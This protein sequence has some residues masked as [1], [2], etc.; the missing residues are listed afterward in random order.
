VSWNYLAWQKAAAGIWAAPA[1][2]FSP[3][4]AKILWWAP[5]LVDGPMTL[6]IDSIPVGRYHE[7]YRFDAP[8]FR[9][10]DRPSGFPTPPVGC[11]QI[12]VIIGARAG[13]VIDRVLP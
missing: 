10:G 8:A 13:S 4:T 5:D 2:A 7:T 3:D 12:G 9:R 1:L 11:Y 6:V